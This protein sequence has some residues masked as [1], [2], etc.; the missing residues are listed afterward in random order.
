[1]LVRSTVTAVNK[2]TVR[3][4]FQLSADCFSAV[5]GV[6]KPR[7]DHAVQMVRFAR[8]AQMV[9]QEAV[10]SLELTLGPDTGGKWN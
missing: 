9:F 1:M 7:S 5:C 3:N 6:P 4:A 2:L 8:A 10:K